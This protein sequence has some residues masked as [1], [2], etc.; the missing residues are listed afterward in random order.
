MNLIFD[1]DGTLT[2]PEEGIVACIRHAL[3]RLG[4]AERCEG[5]LTWCIGPPIRESFCKLLDSDDP[6]LVEEGVTIYRERFAAKGLYENRVYDGIPELLARM[7]EA[8]HG[9]CSSPPRRCGSTPSRSCAISGS[10]A[11]SAASTAPRWT[12]G[13]VKSRNFSPISWRRRTCGPARAS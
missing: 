2:D 4:Y 8:G 12:A 11:I 6:A 10:T 13:S 5:D 1:L 3:E 7:T 9:G